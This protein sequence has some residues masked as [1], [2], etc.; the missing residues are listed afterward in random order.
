VDDLRARFAAASQGSGPIS[1]KFEDVTSPE[2]QLQ[3]AFLRFDTDGNGRLGPSEFQEALCS[4]SNAGIFVEQKT[5]EELITIF[6]QDKD[7]NITFEEFLALLLSE[8]TVARVK[9]P[10]SFTLDSYVAK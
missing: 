4:L 7:G 5:V 10:I 1:L 3:R 2:Y 9:S 8:E 6:D